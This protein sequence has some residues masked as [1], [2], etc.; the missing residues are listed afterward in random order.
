MTLNTGQMRSTAA[1]SSHILTA[2]GRSTLH[3]MQGHKEQSE[4]P[5]TMGGRLCSVSGGWGGPW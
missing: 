5:G 3:T 2:Q 4:Q 1:Y